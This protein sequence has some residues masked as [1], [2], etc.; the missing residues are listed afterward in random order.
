MQ[1][2]APSSQ[3]RLG[4]RILLHL[5]CL[6]PAAIL[7]ANTLRGQL[8]INPVETLLHTA[9]VSSLRILLLCLAVTPLMRLLGAPWLAGYRRLLG[10]WAFF[11]VC[12]HLG[13]YLLFDAAFD[14]GYMYEDVMQ[15][16]YITMGATAFLLL[17]P[18]AITS[19][20]WS[21]RRLG[22]RW[23]QL[24]RLIYA[25]AVLA[26]IHFIWLVKGFQIEPLVYATVLAILLAVRALYWARNHAN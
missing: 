15:R 24:H 4:L 3:A 19:N 11:Y 13:I 20:L 7:L 23:K 8:G 17:L 2:V 5:L 22:R 16:P 12:L 21:Q 9:G 26:C 6:V 25:A 14:P 10:D 1:L 18:L